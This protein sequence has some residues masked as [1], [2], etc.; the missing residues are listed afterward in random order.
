MLAG[1]GA[2]DAIANKAK[3]RTRDE[4][5]AI[6][7]GDKNVYEEWRKSSKKRIPMPGEKEAEDSGEGFRGGSKHI[8]GGR[9]WHTAT[10]PLP[11]ANVKSELKSEAQIVKER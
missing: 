1:V 8:R 7:K 10:A 3:K 6:I 11:N 2:T 4:S 5:G 9:R